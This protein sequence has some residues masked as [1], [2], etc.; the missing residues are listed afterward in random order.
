LPQAI[1]NKL[2]LMMKGMIGFLMMV[3]LDF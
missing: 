3:E 2:T 1:K